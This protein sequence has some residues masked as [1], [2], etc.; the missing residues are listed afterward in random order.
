MENS[1]LAARAPGILMRKITQRIRWDH[2]K[3]SDGSI[4]PLTMGA[5]GCVAGLGTCGHA[6]SGRGRA[7]S[8]LPLR[9]SETVGIRFFELFGGWVLPHV[10]WT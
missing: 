4:Q 6:T 10:G 8:A 3:L 1:G 7:L 9:V 5:I 2:C